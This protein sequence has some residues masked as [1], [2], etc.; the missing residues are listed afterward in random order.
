MMPAGIEAA[1][2]AVAVYQVYLAG[3]I[4]LLT[5]AV[6]VSEK[7]HRTIAALLGGLLMIATGIVSQEEA[8][9]AVDWNV[10][11]LL[12][13]MM[14]LAY[15]LSETGIFQ[16]IAVQAVRLGKGNPFRIMAFLAVF[17][18]ITSA[19][20]DNVTVVVLLAPVT[21]YVA[22][23][24]GLSPIPFLVAEVM[25]SNIGGAATLIGDPPNIL[26][27]SD[28]GID[29]LTFVVHMSPPIIIII[30]LFIPM[31]YFVFRK[32]LVQKE[33][34]RPHIAEVKDLITNPAL[35]KKSLIVLGGVLI[36]FNFHAMMGLEPA[37]V[38]LA[39][40][41]ILMLWTKW[42]PHEALQHVEW[43]TLMFFVGLFI[44]VEAIVK[45]GIIE[46]LAKEVLALTGGSFPLTTMLV[47]WLSALASGIVDNIPYTATM[48]PL[49]DGLIKG[50]LTSP[51]NPNPM[52]WALAL[53]ADLGGNL[54]LVGASA[55]VV[56]AS[57]AARAGHEISFWK[58]FKYSI[59]VTLMSIVVATAYLWIR[60]L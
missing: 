59:W 44:T 11:F 13:G 10:I 24:L 50:G 49:I 46:S 38:A 26:I 29:F 51:H 17:T 35:L 40:A 25:A 12:A 32:D 28:A 1:A 23:N 18:A 55:N 5:Y 20:L 37:T 47:L 43:D 16:W 41:T 27:G 56:A 3:V 14:I 60:Y 58:F 21:L 6:I 4:F 39:G 36:G 7:M 2:E 54:T 8:F 33:G 15:I 48:I 52:W 45:V 19:A 57:L 22:A 34:K 42:E 30:I 31:A 9:I 53:G